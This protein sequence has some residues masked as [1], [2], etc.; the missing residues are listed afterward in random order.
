MSKNE[1]TEEDSKITYTE[2]DF[3][4]WVLELDDATSG[5]I[6]VKIDTAKRAIEGIQELVEEVALIPYDLIAECF[7]F[8]IDG[9]GV[10]RLK[11]VHNDYWNAI[12][13]YCLLLFKYRKEQKRKMLVGINYLKKGLGLTNK[14]V[15]C[16]LQILKDR[17]LIK[18]REEGQK[19]HAIKHYVTINKAV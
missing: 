14:N 18:T 4:D 13:L 12:R 6:Q 17:K 19:L 8:E 9:M 10:L 11:Q 1:H 3:E 15:H 7:T 2:M 5:E 16:A